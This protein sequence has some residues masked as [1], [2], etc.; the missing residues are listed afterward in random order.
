MTMPEAVYRIRRSFTIP[1]AIDVLLLFVLLVLSLTVKGSV[2]ERIVLAGFFTVSLLILIEAVS[3]KIVITDGGVALK[4]LMKIKELLW[5][6]ITHVGCLSLRSKVYILLTTKKGFHILSNAYEPFAPLV[7]D[8]VNHLDTE[9]IEVEAEARAQM[10]KPTKN[11][12]DLVA[13]WVAAVVLSGII[14]LKFIS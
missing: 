10:D 4:K 9:K 3:R 5:S 2:T 12:S 1:L 11:L 7:R 6:D 14:Y 13:A 8:I